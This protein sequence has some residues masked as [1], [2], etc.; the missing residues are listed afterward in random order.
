MEFFE[1]IHSQLLYA[2]NKQPFNNNEGE[3]EGN[4]FNE[5]FKI[6]NAFES[7]ASQSPENTELSNSDEVD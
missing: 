7:S 4:D 3:D 2:E 1:H 5:N 6:N